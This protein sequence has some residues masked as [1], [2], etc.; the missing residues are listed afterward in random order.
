MKKITKHVTCYRSVL[1]TVE[2]NCSWLKDTYS[3]KPCA[4]QQK[5]LLITSAAISERKGLLCEPDDINQSHS[6][7]TTLQIHK[8]VRSITAKG[9]TII[10]FYFFSNEKEPCHLSHIRKCGPV[11]REYEFLALF[12]SLC[13]YCL[14][15]YSEENEAEDWLKCPMCHQWFHEKCFE[16]QPLC[17]VTVNKNNSTR[18][19]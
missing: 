18:Q 7:P 10:D 12:C 2:R 3:L 1:Q 15:K 17:D 13:A 16:L 19:A 11:K 9:D 6:I 8:F 14:K 4:G 5:T